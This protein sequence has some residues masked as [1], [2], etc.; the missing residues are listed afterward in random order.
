MGAALQDLYM[1][2]RLT[3]RY[4]QQKADDERDGKLA[5]EEYEHSL[6]FLVHAAIRV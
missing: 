6:L 4:W 1:Y 3:L 5:G 2:Y